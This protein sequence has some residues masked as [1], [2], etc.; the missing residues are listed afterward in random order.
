MARTA[1]SGTEE[2][3]VAAATNSSRRESTHFCIVSLLGCKIPHMFAIAIEDVF[4]HEQC[5]AI[6]ISVLLLLLPSVVG[7]S[8]RKHT[9][10]HIEPFLPSPPTFRTLLT[11]HFHEP[12]C[13]LQGYIYIHTHTYAIYHLG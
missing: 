13:P 4:G 8:L 10:A 1:S 11:G 6:G 3:V 7:V 12:P 2:S 5:N 9:Y